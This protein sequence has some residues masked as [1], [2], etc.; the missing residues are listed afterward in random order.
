MVVDIGNALST[1]SQLAL[2]LAGF[3]SVLIALS[4]KPSSWTRVDSFRISNLLASSFMAVLISLLPPTLAFFGVSDRVLW[5]ICLCVLALAT[6]SIV[7]L[8]LAYFHRLSPA[9]RTVLRPRLVF[10][11]CTILGVSACSEAAA[12][13]WGEMVSPG[14]FFAGLVVLFAFSIY[15]VVRFLFARPTD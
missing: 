8:A 14:A 1:Y 9:D 13:L 2:G 15:V 11:N 12:G 6:F 7:G 5:K 10:M 3:S 4:G